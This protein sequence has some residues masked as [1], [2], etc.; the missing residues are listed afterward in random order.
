MEWS[1]NI[2]VNHIFILCFHFLPANRV[3]DFLHVAK[4]EQICSFLTP[5][6]RALSQSLWMLQLDNSN[7]NLIQSIYFFSY[8]CSI[9]NNSQKWTNLLNLY[10]FR[11]QKNKNTLFYCIVLYCIVFYCIVF[12]IC[13]LSHY[14]CYY[15]W[16]LTIT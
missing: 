9:S 4:W 13:S 1:W 15:Y 7:S 11:R 6:Y 12:F 14:Y 2:L 10:L 16:G 8:E 3:T 5:S